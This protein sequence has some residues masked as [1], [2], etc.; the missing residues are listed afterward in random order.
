MNKRKYLLIIPILF[1]I[2][3]LPNRI[4]DAFDQK[5][6]NT[7]T[8]VVDVPNNDTGVVDDSN[9]ETINKNEIKTKTNAIMK[10]AANRLSSTEIIVYDGDQLKQVIEDKTNGIETIYFGANIYG[11]SKGIEIG[12]DK[13]NLTINGSDPTTN[14]SYKYFDYPSASISD[15]MRIQ[16]SAMS[17]SKI[18]LKNMDIAGDNYYGSIYVSTAGA[19]VVYDNINYVGPQIIYN[20]NGKSIIKD[21]TINIPRSGFKSPT[22]EVGE[23]FD[24]VFQGQNKITHD[25]PISY[26]SFRFSSN[27]G[28]IVFDK[29]ASLTLNSN[30][31]F[32]LGSYVNFNFIMNENSTFDITNSQ[33]SGNFIYGSN[34]NFEMKSNSTFKMSGSGSQ[35]VIDWGAKDGI[36]KMTNANLT[37][38]TTNDHSVT[39]FNFANMD[40]KD[41]KFTIN[42]NFIS[43]ASYIN[44]N[45]AQSFN[46][47]TLEINQKGTSTAASGVYVSKGGMKLTDSKFNINAENIMPYNL[48]DTDTIELLK[49]DFNFK[50]D[51]GANATL[52]STLI[53]TTGIFS[54]NESNIKIHSLKSTGNIINASELY[55]GPSNNIDLYTKE[56]NSIANSAVEL[57]NDLLIGRGTV[58]KIHIGTI[59]KTTA[60]PLLIDGSLTLLVGYFI[61]FV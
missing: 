51:G 13:M 30:A 36:F 58:F 12:I 48:I 29:D 32:T 33:T 21:S 19:T 46:N 55:L 53:K 28:S 14:K 31:N 61:K 4:I 43:K 59:N 50:L 22:H 35:K 47:S 26:P 49:S 54:L 18:T 1:L 57:K 3:L 27:G 56:L 52:T 60:S 42:N 17:T 44:A 8:G 23:A 40:L 16:N 38:N 20:K 45:F 41:S 7:N 25:T 5:I 10:S 11:V 24:L 39:P 6:S 37:F 15:T 34:G 2:I 9:Q